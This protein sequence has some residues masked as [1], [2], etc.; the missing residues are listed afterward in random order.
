M[1]GLQSPSK[2]RIINRTEYSRQFFTFLGE[3]K[4]VEKGVEK[5]SKFYECNVCKHKLNGT[6]PSNLSCHFQIHRNLYSKLD[7]LDESIEQKR[8]KLLFD[9][10]E[11]V[12]INGNAFRRLSDS[13]LL[14][15]ISNTL[16]ELKAA[17]RG[18]NLK[19]EHLTE[20]KCFMQD[21]A[22]KMKV[23]LSDE[24]NNRPVTLM[25]DITTRIRRSIFGVSAQYIHNGVHKI[26]SIGMVELIDTHTGTHLAS[27]TRKL[28]EKYSVN[29]RQLISITTDN[30][31]N[32]VKMVRD[33]EQQMTIDKPHHQLEFRENMEADDIE[34]ENYLETIPDVT[35]ND[36]LQMIFASNDDDDNDNDDEVHEA[37][38]NLLNA[39]VSD[40]QSQTESEF[41]WEIYGTHCIEHTLQLAILKGIKKLSTENKNIISICR[42]VAKTLRLKSVE[43]ELKNAG[44][45]YTVPHLDVVTRWCSLCVMVNISSH[46]MV[47]L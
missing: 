18:I 6:K 25:A 19:D 28:L 20:V 36:A 41:I 11:I 5:F 24:M 3:E 21:I 22:E 47:K 2:V 40:L 13:G 16:D 7:S 44:I 14:S 38:Q 31:A 39:V 10:V 12:A 15:M 43:Y 29:G 8:L 34:I 32:V 17:G 30:G 26:R 45:L 33:V 46:N 35:D 1:A 4:V 23:K 9:C 27:V 37:N 42:R